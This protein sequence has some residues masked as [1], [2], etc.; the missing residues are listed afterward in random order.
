MSARDHLRS[1][2]ETNAARTMLVDVRTEAEYTFG[3]FL[4]SS[5]RCATLLGSL[6]L[7]RGD[8]V[9]ISLDN[10]VELATL[11]FGCMHLG[12]TIAPINPAFHPGDC[13]AVLEANAPKALI[14]SPRILARLDGHL[15]RFTGPIHCL[16]PEVEPAKKDTVDRIT[17][18]LEVELPKH[19]PIAETFTLEDDETFLV[20]STSGT[21]SRPKGIEITPGSL[22]GNARAFHELLGVG[23]EHRFY[24]VLPMAWLGGF[25][26]LLFLPV[27]AGASVALDG[28]FGPAN[29]YGFWENVREHGINALWFTSTMLSM[30]MALEDDEDLSFV[31]EQVTLGLVGMAP[32]PVELKKRFED[33]FGF[34]LYENYGLSETT[35]ITSNHA[36]LTFK[37]GSVGTPLPHVT[38]TI[39]D[40][41]GG[42]VPTGQEG[43]IVVETPY[44]TRGYR[45]PEDRLE[46]LSTG[47]F[48]TGD[49]GYLDDDGE[50]FVTGRVKDLIIRGGIN[51]SPKAIEDALYELDLVEQVAVVGVPHPVYGE[52]VAVAIKPR[53][54][55]EDATVE[56]V[57]DHCAERLAAYQQPRLI[58]FIDEMPIGATGKV[59]KNVVRRLVQA[60]IDPLGDAA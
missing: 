44:F 36:G 29:L 52:D 45:D 19:E 14:V 17:L 24:N 40:A 31:G 26:N 15:D 8:V 13:A 1:I 55:R 4:E 28:P 58:F 10:S 34:T 30:L 27:S 59:Q 46:R 2:F 32:L 18:D 54:D 57:R 60:K 3:E 47:E 12:V 16:R 50:L 5:R 7:E 35:F 38:V 49:T 39:R 53:A 41:D 33:R 22:L 20:I 43:R 56:E 23:P 25:Y 37:P 42:F 21:T 11:Y 6:G 9:A 51:I 48:I